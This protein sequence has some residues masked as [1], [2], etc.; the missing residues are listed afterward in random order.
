MW[1]GL[2]KEV[3]YLLHVAA[4]LLIVQRMI[5]E[6]LIGAKNKARKWFAV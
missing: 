6:V 3:I 2:W 4:N 5:I 1:E